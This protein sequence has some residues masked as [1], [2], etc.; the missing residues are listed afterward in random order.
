MKKFRLLTIVCMMFLISAVLSPKTHANAAKKTTLKTTQTT[1]YVNGT[2]TIGLK[3]KKSKATYSFTSNKTSVAKVNSKGKITALRKGTAKIKVRYKLNGSFKSVGSFKVTVVKSGL[4]SDY[5]TWKPSVGDKIEPSQYLNNPNK[6]AKYTIRSNNTSV[7]SGDADGIITAL[8]AGSAT[9]SIYEIYNSKARTIG[10]INVTVKGATIINP[11]IKM[12]YNGRVD[13]T[14]LMENID[15]SCTY[16]L[17]PSNKDLLKADSSN[18]VSI[19]SEE[20]D[21]T[22]SVSIQEISSDGLIRDVGTVSVTLTKNPFVAI[23][24]QQVYIGLGSTL[25]LSKDE[26][27]FV[28]NKVDDAAYTFTPEDTSIISEDLT[29]LAF[30]T[31]NVKITQTVDQVNT[32]LSEIVTVTVSPAI[33][34]E[35]LSTEGFTTMVNG[36]V[37]ADYPIQ[38]RN[39]KKLYFYESADTKI[40]T[41][42]T[43]GSSIDEDYLIIN[44]V[45]IGQTT[46]KVYEKDSASTSSKT[47]VGTFKVV[48]DADTSVLPDTS[49]LVASDIIS[50]IYFTH[51]NK[52]VEGTVNTEE[53]ACS[54]TDSEGNGIIDFGT[55]FESLDA[56]CFNIVMNKSKYYI[57]EYEKSDDGFDWNFIINLGDD[58]GTTVELPITLASA[59]INTA[60]LFKSINVKLGSYSRTI[61]ATTSFPS[62]SATMQFADAN[63]EFEVAFKASEYIAAGATEYNDAA[64]DPKPLSSLKNVS[65]TVIQNVYTKSS[66]NGNCAISNISSPYTDDNSVFTFTVTFEDGNTVDYSVTLGLS[67]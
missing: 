31:T 33:I 40:C 27:I 60:S 37:Y 52:S 66:K 35:E 43:A 19:T 25:T 38:Y 2:Y 51:N 8:R 62:D 20:Y 10:K 13:T 64:E 44:P 63:T 6:S 34:K 56:S 5:S 48:V 54:F 24:D 45:K 9:L 7:A 18:V 11:S 65:C 3:N 21:Q 67:E 61:T 49:Q 39:H 14:D 42:S 36:N 30:G 46:I 47:P 41:V 58:D 59:E 17:T 26:G 32:E 29:A 55:N 50:H 23:E 15:D 12:A 22:C 4:K 53:L 28:T 1:M 57:Q 16:L